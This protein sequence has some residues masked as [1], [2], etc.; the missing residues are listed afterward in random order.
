MD[1]P[2]I[3]NF[4]DL[5]TREDENGFWIHSHRFGQLGG[6][7]SKVESDTVLAI[8]KDAF[9]YAH[10]RILMTECANWLDD[11]MKGNFNEV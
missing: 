6:P 2:D 4:A 7:F 11:I 10:E 5:Y 9:E 1:K 3:L 8:L